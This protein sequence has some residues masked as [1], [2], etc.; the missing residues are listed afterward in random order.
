MTTNTPTITF[1]ISDALAGRTVTATVTPGYLPAGYSVRVELAHDDGHGAPWDEE[2]G[3]VEVQFF[4][5][6]SDV[7][8]GWT[9]LASNTRRGEWAYN[10]AA[11]IVKAAREGW[12]VA[13][14]IAARLPLKPG[15]TKPTRAQITYAA[16][17]ENRRRL[18]AY[19][20]DEWA[21]YGIELTLIDPQGKEAAQESL[22]GIESDA[23]TYWHEVA[24][25]LLAEAAHRAGID[26]D[27]RRAAWR[28]AL[29]EA[30]EAH[31]WAQRDVIT[32]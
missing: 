11:A 3:H 19:L 30:R 13:P 24:A 29:R 20:R 9:I 17:K 4:N 16:V 7:P 1:S 5:R 28:K 26:P 23:G 32:T 14:H 31:Y 12:G 18:S 15:R 27:S 25:D 21:Y 22:W 10:T 2:D 8:R 6:A